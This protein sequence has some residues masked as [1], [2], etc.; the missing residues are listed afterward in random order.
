MSPALSQVV[1]GLP[2]RWVDG[3]RWVRPPGRSCHAP[4]CLAGFMVPFQFH[5]ACPAHGLPSA[6][7]RP[8][9]APEGPAGSRG[10]RDQLDQ[11]LPFYKWGIWGPEKR[12]TGARSRRGP[13]TERPLPPC[14]LGTAPRHRS[15]KNIQASD[16][17]LSVFFLA[18]ELPYMKYDPP[19]SATA[20]ETEVSEGTHRSHQ[21]KL[22]K[23]RGCL[24]LGAQPLF[25]SLR[26]G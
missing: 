1:S 16:F 4:T 6:S 19:L 20:G 11:P 12:G 17:F 23:E 24:V 7:P 26:A 15:P 13:V 10:L 5:G 21:E 14:P 3:V 2:G 18:A 22:N 8:G 25:P 9:P